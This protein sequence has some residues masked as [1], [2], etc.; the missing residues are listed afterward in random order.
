[1]RAV[2]SITIAAALVAAFSLPAT[3]KGQSPYTML[4]GPEDIFDQVLEALGATPSEVMVPPDET[5][6]QLYCHSEGGVL[7]QHTTDGEACIVMEWP[8]ICTPPGEVS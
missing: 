1:M 2:K 4:C 6:L 8:A 3:A 7:V 5:A